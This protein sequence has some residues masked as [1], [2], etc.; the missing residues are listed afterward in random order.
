MT[1]I[2][3]PSRAGETRPTTEEKSRRTATGTGVPPTAHGP[4]PLPGTPAALRALRPGR[5]DRLA[6]GI[7]DLLVDRVSATGG[8]LGASLGVVELTIAL[9]R[10]FDSPRDAILFDTGHQSYPHKVLTGRAREFAT[11]RQQGGLSGY[12][13]RAESAH[14]WIENSH[15]STALAYADGLAKAFHLRGAARRVVAVVGDGALTG[16]LAFEALNNLG[17]AGRPVIVVLND[18]TRSYDPSAGALPAHLARLRESGQVTPDRNVFTDLGFAYLGPVDGHDI[19][20]LETALRRAAALGRPVVVHAVTTKGKGYAP[21]EADTDDRMHACGVIDPATGRPRTT[22]KPTWTSVFA[23]ELAALG[24][25]REDLVALTAAMR[26]PVG[27]GP[28]SRKFPDRV[29]DSGIAEQHAVTS[30]AGLAMGGLHPVVC[31]YATFLNRAFDQVLMD[32]ALHR[33]PV[34]F[35]LD[36][37]GVTGPDGPSHHGLWDLAV[38]A[39][40]PG[41]RV[42]APRDPARLRAL[43]REAVESGD[44]PSTVRFPKAAAAADIDP[45][46]TMDGIDVLH[47]SPHAPL[48]VLLVAIG[49]TA[50]ACLE[51]ARL[52]AARGI[53]VTVVDPR[54]VAPV[55]PALVHL[56]GRHRIALSVEDGVREGGIG[57][58][59]AQHATDA[60]VT[61]PVHALGLPTRFLAHGERGA[62]L[63]AAGISGPAIADTA[64][65]LLEHGAPSAASLPAP[66]STR[67]TS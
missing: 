45:L 28:F 44:G 4:L 49:T 46:T 42:A 54:W 19:P 35:V 60:G 50:G 20:A 66:S 34:T 3:P 39:R 51:A 65:R 26:L 32:V 11:L 37:A 8:H 56:A 53:G 59:L 31:L 55:N 21:A 58:L 38:L 13:S 5:L 2:D 18:N 48:D 30:A 62:L 25:E 22:G 43:L 12:P 1:A 17:A 52:L 27:L 40:V 57:A 64:R 15:A 24:G 9:H 41:M 14:D 23:A 33:L 61:V 47:R 29:F 6:A 36:R 67:S 63:S 10:V 16:D 7:R